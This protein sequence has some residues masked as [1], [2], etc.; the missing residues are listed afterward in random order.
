MWFESLQRK[1][2]RAE[3]LN[4]KKIQEWKYTS[5]QAHICFYWRRFRV[6]LKT[7]AA[8]SPKAA[9][10]TSV[11]VW[12]FTR[13]TLFLPNLAFWER[14]VN[15]LSHSNIQQL[16]CERPVKQTKVE[17]NYLFFL[18]RFYL[19]QATISLVPIWW[20]DLKAA[21]LTSSSSSSSLVSPWMNV[22]YTA[23]SPYCF[24]TVTAFLMN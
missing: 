8:V 19:W 20:R 14:K 11:S 24:F 16:V 17:V 21:V 13:D 15:A 5:V 2:L 7:F 3:W 10:Y 9:D 23:P 4:I 6:V 1:N 12:T 22:I 18:W